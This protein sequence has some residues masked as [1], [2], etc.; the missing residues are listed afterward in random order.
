MI[1]CKTQCVNRISSGYIKYVFPIILSEMTREKN[2]AMVFVDR[3]IQK[4]HL[5]LRDGKIFFTIR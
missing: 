3:S 1:N 5:L 2:I 4:Q